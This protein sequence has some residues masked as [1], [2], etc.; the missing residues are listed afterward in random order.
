MQGTG[1]N[2]SPNILYGENEQSEIWIDRTQKGMNNLVLTKL[3]S[4]TIL[5][6]CIVNQV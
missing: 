4:P 3:M 2:C 5:N 6:L 1:F